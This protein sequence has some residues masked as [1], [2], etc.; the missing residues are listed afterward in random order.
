VIGKTNI[1]LQYFE[2]VFTSHHWMVRVYRYVPTHLHVC[3][4]GER[5]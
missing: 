1:K 5:N 3:G 4:G 2:E